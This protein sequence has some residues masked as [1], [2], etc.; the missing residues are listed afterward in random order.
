MPLSDLPPDGVVI[1]GA[2]PA[3][4]A[5]A[6]TL[7]DQGDTFVTVLD[8]G[9]GAGGQYWRQPAPPADSS[10]PGALRPDA[11]RGLHHD[12]GTFAELRS[13]LEAGQAAGRASLL[14]DHHVWTVVAAEGGHV[15]HAVDRSGGPGRE[16]AVELRARH[17]V[18]ATGAHDRSLPFPGWD[19]PGVLTAGGLQALLKAG[20]VA[21][22]PRVAV[23]GTGP[24]LLPVAAGLADRGATVV[25]VF[26]ANSPTRWLREL[27]AVAANRTKLAEGAGYAA[28]L[29]RRRVPVRTRT[30]IVE[31][32]GRE[33]VEAVT[34]A[35]VD[36]SGHPRRDTHRRIEVDA[37]GVGW[38]FSP[39]LD[40]AVTLGCALTT[41]AS[42]TP[43][44]QVDE[45]QRTSRSGVS[46]AGE[47]CGV[48]GA[49]LAVAEGRLAARGIVGA[50]A[51]DAETA[52]LRG[53]VARLRAFAAA[54]HRAHPVPAGWADALRSDTVVCR[55]EE[56]SAGTVRHA[57]AERGAT[58]ARQVKQ[59]TRAGMGW[60]QGRVCGH[61]VELLAGGG[62]GSPAERLV[63]TP[64]PLGVLAS[65]KS[66]AM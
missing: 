24:F 65:R 40:L 33:R 11:M 62:S 28:T 38:G 55:C 14:T 10:D 66:R 37:V 48:G 60:C 52:G 4:L 39:Q 44:V 23:G 31:A 21:L 36:A 50:S 42:G 2:G 19:L 47:A 51:S 57:I 54:M 1:V 5:C 53:E 18:I 16:R 6:A 13:R 56:V 7:L 63:S 25:G 34:V 8:A 12:L 45:W 58:D 26:E 15:V 20:D 30:M 32:H 61:A 17:L 29:L 27:R 9:S 59:L 35:R 41:D 43:V 22:G 64:L 46:A 49:A 3:G